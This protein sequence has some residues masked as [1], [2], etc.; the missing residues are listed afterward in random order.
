MKPVT[1]A[2]G[3]LNGWHVLFGMIAFFL[4]VTAVDGVMIYKAVSTFSGDT[5][6]AYRTGLAYNQRIADERRQ[7]KLGWTQSTK[8]DNA[9]GRFN[10]TLKD[11]EGRGLE[12][13]QISA[14]IG[15]PATD[16]ADHSL[17][18]TDKGQ[19]TY[20][21]ALPD[22]AEGVWEI[23]LAVSQSPRGGIVYRSKV[24]VWRQP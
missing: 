1:E 6:N 2:R 15:R 22:L 5:P 21:V 24:S 8:F 17:T 19:G 10:F 9:T 7:D 12:G 14:E 11:S 18:L 16:V 3:G 20:S 13:L 23:A 4:A